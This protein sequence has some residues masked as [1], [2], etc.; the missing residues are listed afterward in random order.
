MVA[1]PEDM[2]VAPHFHIRADPAMVKVLARARWWQRLSDKGRCT[3]TR[4]LAAA[5]KL[6]RG[7]TGTIL[8][9]SLLAPDIVQ[10]ILEGRPPDGLALPTPLEPLPAEWEQQRSALINAVSSPA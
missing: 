1:T 10:T 5:E 3:S 2:S 4:E 7:Y 8:R 6:D 9:L